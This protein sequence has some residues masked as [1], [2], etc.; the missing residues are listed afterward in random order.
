MTPDEG[1]WNYNFMGSKH[2]PSMI[3]SLKIDVPKDFYHESHRPTHFLNFADMEASG[4]NGQD[5]EETLD[6]FS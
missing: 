6:V 3:Y 5:N 2:T 4:S 1:V